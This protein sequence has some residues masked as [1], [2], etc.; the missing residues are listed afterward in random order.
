MIV[1]LIRNEHES[2]SADDDDC[3]DDQSCSYHRGSILYSEGEHIELIGVYKYD[4]ML[5]C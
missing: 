4:Y 1:A 2:K 3:R 5:T